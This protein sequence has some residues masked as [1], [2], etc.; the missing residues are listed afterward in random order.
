MYAPRW[1]CQPPSAFQLPEYQIA[2]LVAA[3]VRRSCALERQG[4]YTNMKSSFPFDEFDPDELVQPPTLGGNILGKGRPKPCDME[5]G[6][7][8]IVANLVG[9]NDIL[10]LGCYH[11]LDWSVLNAMLAV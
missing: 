11:E 4:R 8:L 6:V 1:P 2:A 10:A 7:E 5:D 9:E 3:I